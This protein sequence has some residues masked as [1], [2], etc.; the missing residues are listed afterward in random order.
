MKTFCFLNF[1]DCFFTI[2]IIF[3]ACCYCVKTLFSFP[4]LLRGPKCS[5]LLL[6]R[7]N[8]RMQPQSFLSGNSSILQTCSPNSLGNMHF[9][10]LQFLDS[11]PLLSRINSPFASLCFSAGAASNSSQGIPTADQKRKF[12]PVQSLLRAHPNTGAPDITCLRA[13]AP[14]LA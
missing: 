8:L 12:A 6:T 14:G 2:K 11:Q 1:I 4:V 7:E 9:V 5:Q 10:A 3:T 13:L